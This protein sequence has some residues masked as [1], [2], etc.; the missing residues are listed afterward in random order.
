VESFKSRGK[1]FICHPWPEG[2]SRDDFAIEFQQLNGKPF[3]VTVIIKKVTYTIFISILGL[4]SL[5]LFVGSPPTV[6]F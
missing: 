2:A 6:R 3:K 1:N 5:E 4:P